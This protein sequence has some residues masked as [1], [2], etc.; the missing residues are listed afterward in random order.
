MRNTTLGVVNM[1]MLQFRGNAAA[2]P[3]CVLPIGKL[4]VDTVPVAAGARFFQIVSG[5]AAATDVS[6]VFALAL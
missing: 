1:T 6:V 2:N 3:V 4:S 5:A